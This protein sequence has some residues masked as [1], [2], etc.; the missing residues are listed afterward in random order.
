MSNNKDSPDMLELTGNWNDLV[1]QD[2]TNSCLY[3]RFER[4]AAWLTFA[5]AM[6]TL[7]AA[8]YHVI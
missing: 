5:V 6:V 8:V 4:P 2:K 3:A 7:M 1:K